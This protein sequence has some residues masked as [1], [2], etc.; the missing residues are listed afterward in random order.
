MLIECLRHLAASTR[1]PDEI[2]IADASPEA[3]R[4]R[5]RIEREV[6]LPVT[7]LQPPVGSAVQRN[8]ILDHIRSD[9]I[10][11]PDD[12]TLVSP[13]FVERIMA[14]YEAD[15]EGRVGGVDGLPSEGS[16][17]PTS[18]VPATCNENGTGWRRHVRRARVVI[19]ERLE[20]AKRAIL[21]NKF[22]EAVLMPV[23]GIPD[24]VKHLNVSPTCSL[25]GCVM[26]YRTPIARAY[27][28]NER[29]KRYGFLEDFEI[30]YRIGREHTLLRCL[31]AHAQHIKASGGRLHPSVYYY[32]YLV[33]LAYVCRTV[34]EWSP[35]LRDYVVRHARRY[36]LWEHFMS[37]VKRAGFSG[38]RGAKAGLTRARALLDAPME[39]VPRLFD[40]AT[41]EALARGCF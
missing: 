37:F 36:V 18:A 28:F 5:Q 17:V 23:H 22:P 34:M 7:F 32:V 15:V 9:V 39:E 1:Q 27:R 3:E 11:F 10:I 14:V 6:T 33:N 4:H 12:D 40:A 8:A 29:L 16:A 38:Y 41:D 35:E 19:V 21:G 2:V 20:R 31:D 13:Q 26:S 24:T 25:Y 30:S